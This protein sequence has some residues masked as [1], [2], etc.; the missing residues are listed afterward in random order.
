V[1]PYIFSLPVTDISQVTID[2]F[3][4]GSKVAFVTFDGTDSDLKSWMSPS[5][6]LNSSWS[7]LKSSTVYDFSVDECVSTVWDIHTANWHIT[8]ITRGSFK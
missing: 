1:V 6:L 2:L 5:R 4:G 7:S 3:K 8:T